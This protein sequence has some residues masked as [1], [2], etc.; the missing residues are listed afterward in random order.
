MV[1]PSLPRHLVPLLQPDFYPHAPAA[2]ELVQTHIS[3]VFLAGDE[4]YKVKK[5]VRFSFLDFSS[6]ERRHHFCREEVRL[7]RRLAPDVYLGIVAICGDGDAYRLGAEDDPA[8]VEY[9][10]HMRRLRAD[11]ILANLLT[12][13][14]VTPAMIDPIA[15]RIAAFHAAA[16]A[17]DA[18]TANGSIDAVWR[19]LSDNFIGAA[20][21]RDRT[22]P[23]AD[24][25]RIQRFCRR[26]LDDHA[27][28]FARRQQQHRIRE[29]HG[30]L[31]SEHISLDDGVAVFDCVEFN[32]RFR[33]CDVAAEVAFLAMDLDYRGHPALAQRFVDAY[34]ARTGDDELRALLPFYS[35][36]RAY[37][38]GKVDSLKSDAAEVEPA[39]RHMAAE[40]AQRHF[41]LAYRYSWSAVHP[42]VVVFGLS[43]SGK[44]VIARGLSR[45]TGFVYFGSDEI[46]KELAGMP[47]QT[48]GSADLYTAQRSAQTYRAMLDRAGAAIA[49]GRGAIIDAT[50]QLRS[51]RDGA[52]AIAT[53]AI[54]PIVFVECTAPEAVVRT[55]L[56][57]RAHDAHEASD[58]DWRIYERQRAVYEPFAADEPGQHV[59]LD[60]TR[61]VA[62]ALARI[63]SELSA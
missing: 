29:C 18:I 46:R 22:I 45:R 4:V 36:Y 52:R 41:A 15:A 3:F 57:R 43:G 5:P 32:P 6:L 39:D 47:P 54:T 9:A 16:D 51:H 58:A 19:V 26:F 60:T 42:L 38:R 14:A 44:S 61:P 7:N 17:D 48:R 37:V 49:S 50:F 28:L 55:R 53:V 23:A 8:A 63:E 25:D 10:V 31:H 35:C 12:A 34:V 13:R 30:D 62:D 56:A 20:P 11:R 1:N 33:N 59:L 2:V 24:D 27:D 40:S 21:F